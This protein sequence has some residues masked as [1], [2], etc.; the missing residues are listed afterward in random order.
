MGHYEG[1]TP[2]I[3]TVGV[4]VGPLSMVDIFGTPHSEAMHLVERYR[5][6]DYEAA[7]RATEKAIREQGYGG[8]NAINEGVVFDARYRG[9]GPA[10]P[11]HGE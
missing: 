5:L 10:S 4:K 11:V 1:D 8:G 2:V 7:K 6:I 9:Q 3:D